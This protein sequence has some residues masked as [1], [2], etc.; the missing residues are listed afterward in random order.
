[1]SKPASEL[2]L[3]GRIAAFF[4][5]SKLTPLLVIASLA[6]GGLA[7]S[8]T[9]REEEPQ[10]VVPIVDVFVGLPGASPEEVENLVTVPVERRMYELP[11]VEYVYSASRPGVAMVTVRFLVGDDPEESLVKVHDRLQAWRDALPAN[12]TPHLVRLRSIDDVP[13]L[14]LTLW[15]ERYGGFEL[16]RMAAEL[17]REIA[18]VD[19]VSDVRILGG[20]RRQVRVLLDA[21]GMAAR[22]VDPS[23]VAAAIR[24]QNAA[25]P[26]GSFENSDRE[27]LVETGSF[28]RDLDE[29]ASLVV[30][31][32]GENPVYLRDV[33]EVVDGAEEPS[34]HV[35]FRTGAAWDGAAVD[36][37]APAVTLSIAKRKGADAQRV[38]EGV[39]A[40]VDELR[41][42]LLPADVEVTVTR[43]YG[44]TAS[45]KA[46]ELLV[47]LIGAILSVTLVIGVFL[48]W[49]GALVVFVSVPVSFA[50]TLFVYYV[51]GYTL[52]RVT[53][54]A[55]IFVT[56]I[57]VDDSII[58]VENIVRHLA[59]K[60]VSP[61]RA[62]LQA[63]DEVG[64][65]TILATLTVIAAV[66]PMA[67]V[68]GLM[69]PYMLPM[70]V[71]ASLAMSFSLLVA[72]I[73]APWFAYR[74]VRAGGHGTEGEGLERTFTYRVYR[75]LMQPLLTRPRR[76][77]VFLGAITVL[78][79]LSVLLFPL[80]WVSVKMLPFDNK[81]EVQVIVD[82]PEGTTLETTSRVARE[83]ADELA[84]VPEVTD[85]QLYAGIAAPINFNGL[86]RHYDLRSGANVA[87]LQVN[88]VH[89]KERDDQ[90]HPIAKRLRTLVQAVAERH[91]A[92]VK[93]VEIPPGPPVLS[94]LLAEVY[95]PTAEERLRVARQ[96]R[97]VF[98]TTDGVVDVDWWQE[99]PQSKLVFRVDREKAALHG[100]AA[101]EIVRTLRLALSGEDAGVLHVP[102]EVEPVT[103][104]LELP[105]AARSSPAELGDVHLTSMSGA[106]VPLSELV[107][108]EE[109]V[110][111]PTLHRKNLRSVVYVAGEVAGSNESPVYA[112]LDMAGRVGAIELPAGGTLEQFYRDEPLSTERASMK[113]DGEW[114]ITYEVFRDLG[115]A[116]GAVLILIY[117]LI[118]GWFGSLRVPL[119]MMIAIPL[120]LVGILPGHFFFGAFFTATSM[121][122][123]IALAGIMVRNSVLLIDFVHLALER[124]KTLAEAVV[125][126]GSVRF[127][128]IL[129]T[130]GTVVV[131]AV[132]ILFDP[133]FQGLALSLMFGAIAST[134]LTLVV[135]PLVYFM[136]ERRGVS[137][138]IPEAWMAAPAAAEEL[139]DELQEAATHPVRQ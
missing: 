29:V 84:A 99:D 64:N 133:I 71:G 22:G 100:V 15:S 46:G 44:A 74:L 125:E 66:L 21:E 86:V 124:G 105:R 70:P 5:D 2:G 8:L 12:A 136:I 10:I 112:I 103:L 91:G 127:R 134:A 6:L 110:L 102:G 18:V 11:G 138:A 1:M 76:G 14:G 41:G 65:P 17:E 89:K 113:W 111:Q 43:D 108:V 104:R 60:K 114:H 32:Y 33:A 128:P 67:F 54:F 61:L 72:L 116:F 120:S 109:S 93:V 24:M 115:A 36:G 77:W 98:A 47:H 122:G 13:V 117:L 28:L 39:M 62:A 82:M 48:G 34:S 94:T 92:N 27:V 68:R 119:V 96:V 73:A 3:A 55:L 130:A 135:V 37:L 97:E 25:A 51:L 69:G 131:G 85:L 137:Q 4:I 45:E 53:L 101:A 126:A 50:L 35:F 81:S 75:R 80:R 23:R 121:I 20:E 56:G 107:R 123:F 87:D 57:V 139:E 30:G 38:V 40:R 42:R 78:L 9:S 59:E 63:I 31:V 83:I 129:L 95:G 132:V 88:L 118:V 26:A 106:S 49:R 58:V 79:L 90:S 16:R 19:D 7:V 52:N